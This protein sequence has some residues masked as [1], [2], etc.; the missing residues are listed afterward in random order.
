MDKRVVEWM[1]DQQEAEV[2]DDL[3]YLA[4]MQREGID[5][6]DYDMMVGT[7]DMMDIE[8]EFEDKMKWIYI[9]LL[10]SVIHGTYY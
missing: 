10:L 5:E 9:S 6:T 3:N 2:M 4:Y 7:D 1:N 8:S